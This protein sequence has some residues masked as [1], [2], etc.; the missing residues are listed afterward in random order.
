[1]R[2]WATR[3]SASVIAPSAVLSVPVASI[4]ASR[5]IGASPHRSTNRQNFRDPLI[6]SG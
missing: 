4:N 2:Q 1:M 6:A 5:S 3:F